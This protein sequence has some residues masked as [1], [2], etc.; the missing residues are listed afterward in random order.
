MTD[1]KHIVYINEFFHPDI[2]AS[3]AVLTEQLPRLLRLRD[4]LRI[5]VITGNRAWDNA[6]TVYAPDGEYEGVRIVRVKRSPVGRTSLV[7]RGLGFLSFGSSVVQAAG[8][9]EPADLVIG[10]T[11]PPQGGMLARRVAGRFGCP[12]IYRVLDLYPD[13]A[14]TVGRLSGTGLTYRMWRQMDTKTMERAARIVAIGEAVAQRIVESRSVSVDRV[15]TLHDGFD[16]Q[17]VACP[18]QNRFKATH[19]PDGRVVVQFAGNMGLSHPLETIIAAARALADDAG[20]RFLFVGGGP[21]RASLEADLP[22][23]AALVDYQPADRLG[24]VLDAADICLI[25]QHQ[26]MFDQAL[27]YRV[28]AILAAA[29]P[30]V[31]IGDRRSE[32]ASW[33]LDHDCGIHVDQGNTLGLAAALRGLAGDSDRRA[34]MG[35]NARALFDQ[36]FHADRTAERWLEIID[37]AM[38]G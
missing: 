24:E 12:F 32:V 11:A 38:G 26:A 17:R 29:K 19:N 9:I 2:C 14:A 3:A 6:E 10:T 7:R 37:A 1:R 23:N 5:T 28:Y 4:D 20:M 16:P 8:R 25:S 13:V 30:A 15:V 33:L 34:T 27:P 36:R 35:R 31:F 18:A 21:Q 22:P